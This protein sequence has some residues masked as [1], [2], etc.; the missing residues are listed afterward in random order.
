[1]HWAHLHDRALL[2]HGHLQEYG[3]QF[4]LRADS[5]ERCPLL[6]PGSLDAR[7]ASVGLPPAAV[8]LESVQDR[9]ALDRRAQNDLTSL[10][11]KAA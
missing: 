1:Q 6:A 2:N 4:L 10:P 7:R 3:T 9:Y 11:W 5:V 8:A